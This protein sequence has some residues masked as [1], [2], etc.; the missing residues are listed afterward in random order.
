MTNE[1][2]IIVVVKGIIL[3]AGKVLIIKR[4]ENDDINAGTWECVGGKIEFGEEL[5]TALKREVNE[6]VGLDITVERLLFATTFKTDPTR[7]VVILTYLCRSDKNEVVLSEEH[8]GYKWATKD[9]L[10]QFL[11]ADIIE[12]FEKNN[13]FSM[14]ELQ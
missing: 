8:M 14:G 2:R 10:K 11:F 12:D 3:Q 13:I 1:N 9:Q 4:A 7:Q 6:E 5:E